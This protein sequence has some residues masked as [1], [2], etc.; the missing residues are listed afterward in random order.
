MNRRCVWSM[1]LVKIH[2]LMHSMTYPGKNLTLNDLD[3]RSNYQLTI[4]DNH[5]TNRCIVMR[6]VPSFPLFFIGKSDV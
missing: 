4:S 5:Y 6:A 1:C 2:R 3:P